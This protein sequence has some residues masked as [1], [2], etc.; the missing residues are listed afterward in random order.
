[1]DTTRISLIERLQSSGEAAWDEVL[2][3]Y[4]PMIQRWLYSH[5]IRPQDADDIS[6]EVLLR[7]MHKIQEFEHNGN[8]GAFRSWL[9]HITL[10]VMRNFRRARSTRPILQD[11]AVADLLNQV[12]DPNSDASQEFQRQHNLFLLHKLLEGL[13]GSFSADN[14]EMF[15]RYCINDEDPELIAKDFGVPKN[16]VYVAKFRVIR[17]LR[18]GSKDIDSLLES[19]G[20]REPD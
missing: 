2:A 4:A 19:S 14:L 11:E 18:A 9:Q 17:T 5:Q 12:E 7:L 20:L 10:N 3:T 1:M 15:R 6:Q 16:T 13:Q 8:L